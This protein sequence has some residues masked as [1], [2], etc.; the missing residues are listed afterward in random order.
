MSHHTHVHEVGFLF[1]FLLN[2]GYS[3]QTFF[4]QDGKEVNSNFYQVVKTI[5][6]GNHTF[7]I[8]SMRYMSAD[9]QNELLDLMAAQVQATVITEVKSA[10]YYS[11]L[12]DE[13]TDITNHTQLCFALRYGQLLILM[14]DFK[15]K[16]NAIF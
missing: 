2:L 15:L 11:I 9:V 3:L 13:S 5:L 12:A 10:R 6:E 1:S 7:T 16:M 4:G 14:L 8:Q